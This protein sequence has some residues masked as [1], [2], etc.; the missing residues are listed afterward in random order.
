VGKK[1]KV[2]IDINVIVSAFGWYGKPREI[3]ALVTKG[4]ILNCISI[5]MLA[6]LRRVLGYPKL[7]FSEELQAEIIETVFDTSSLVN[8]LEEISLVDDDPED[9]KILE[10]AASAKVEFIISGDKHLLNLK[11]FKG[12]EIVTPEEFLLKIILKS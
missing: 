8:V 6:E 1:T 4:E 7:S 5:E 3:L 12:V 10:C 9:N 11:S 2:V